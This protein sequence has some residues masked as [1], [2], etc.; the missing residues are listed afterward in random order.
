MKTFN[1][2]EAAEFPKMNP[3]GVRRLTA[4]KKFLRVTQLNAGVF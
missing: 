4:R 1:L 2:E 3:E